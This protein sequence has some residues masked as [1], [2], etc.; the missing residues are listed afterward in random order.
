M[1]NRIKKTM[2]KTMAD[3]E[4][5]YLWGRERIWDGAASKVLRWKQSLALPRLLSKLS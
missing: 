5:K 1:T 4:G 3:E 2:T